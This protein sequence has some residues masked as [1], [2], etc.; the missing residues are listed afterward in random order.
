MDNEVFR[1]LGISPDSSK[2][3]IKKSFR[4]MIFLC[5]PDSI[6]AEKNDDLNASK[7]IDAYKK[8]LKIAYEKEE[9]LNNKF[10]KKFRIYFDRDYVSPEKIGDFYGLFFDL[11]R[12][13]ES[14]LYHRDFIYFYDR[15]L[16]RFFKEVVVIDDPNL[17]EE[18]VSIFYALKVLTDSRK[19]S[20]EVL[21]REEYKLEI[22]RKQ[23]INYYK[24]VFSQKDYLSFR[25]E[26]NAD[27]DRIVEDILITLKKT[28]DEN[29][30][31]EINVFLF[32]NSIFRE[33]YFFDK[34]WESIS[35]NFGNS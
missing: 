31:S 21:S 14:L 8:A 25:Q 7:I 32:L 6:Y 9:T 29:L 33:E 34:A 16:D 13:F 19:K 4:K 12:R 23:F 22:L 3:A 11:L 28:N 24:R 35:K 2:E 30:K 27:E 20:L 15:I 18:I 5:H 17:R 1:I 26:I 10:K